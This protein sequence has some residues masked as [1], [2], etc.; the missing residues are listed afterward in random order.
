MY[1]PKCR[2]PCPADFAFCPHCGSA[3]ESTCLRCGG[4][5]PAGAAF[6]PRC[7]APLVG[8][9]ADPSRSFSGGSP[10]SAERT[11]ELGQEPHIAADQARQRALER[12]V[13]REY[14]EQLLATRD[15]PA[16]PQRRLITILFCDVVGSVAI[17]EGLDPEEV[18]EVMNGAFEALIRPVLHH[19]GTLARLMGDAI[20]A[21]FGAPVAHEDDPERAVRASLEMVENAHLYAARL[22]QERGLERFSV[23]AGI[24]TGLVA[25]GEV[26][27]DLRVEYTAMGD[28]VNLAARLEAAAPPGGV[29][30]THDTY[31]HVRGRFDVV[32][33][34]P[35]TVKG[36][37]GPVQ[38]YLVERAK[39][40]AFPIGSRGVEGIAT[41][42]VGRDAELAA[43]QQ[44][45]LDA[46]DGHQARVVTV[47]G[48]AGIGKSRLL[49]E[50]ASWVEL[51]PERV[52][53]WKARAARVS[54]SVPYGLL[55]N[56]FARRFGI[57]DSD[58]AAVALTRFR[59]GMA[60][61]L[62]AEQAD[63]AGH[64]AGFDFSSSPTVR[65]LLGS[66]SFGQIASAS[67]RRALSIL[68]RL[69]QLT[70]VP[71]WPGDETAHGVAYGPSAS[72]HEEPALLL[73]EDLHWADDASL[74]LIAGLVAEAPRARLLV[75]AAARPQ[76]LERRPNWGE[77]LD[78][79]VRLELRPLSRRSGRALV[80]E[81]L[82]RAAEVPED[83]CEML[84]DGSEGNP[85]FLEELVKMLIEDG[86]IE[87]DVERWHIDG[88]RL[89]QV[90]LPPT[91]T[92]VLQARLDALPPDERL[93]LQRASVIGRQFWDSLVVELVPEGM[94]VGAL[95]AALRSR[96]LVFRRERPAFDA[97][98]EYTFKHSFLREVTY[99]T[100]L[101]HVRRNCHG[102]VARWLE[103]HAGE[104]LGEYLALIAEHWRL[105]GEGTVAAG[106]YMRAGERAAALG[107]MT[108]ARGFF[109][110][111]LELLPPDDLALRWRALAGQ[112]EVLG[113]L[114]DSDARQAADQALLVLAQQMGDD[115]RLAE[116]H[117]RRGHYLGVLSR[118]PE[119][120]EALDAALA[121][122][123][124][125]G[126]RHLR[127]KTLP[128][129]VFTLT[130]MGRM[131]EAGAITGEAL[132]CAEMPGEPEI[133]ARAL[134]NVSIYYAAA[135]DLSRAAQLIARQA[136]TMQQVGNPV[137]QAISL[138]NLGYYYLLLGLYPK[139]RAALEHALA[140]SRAIGARREQ[141]YNQLNL[142]LACWR[143]GDG[144]TARCLL[145]DVIPELEALGDTFGRASGQN[146]LA[147]VLEHSGDAM[148]AAQVFAQAQGAMDQ[149][150]AR[151]CAADALAG[152]TRCRM[153]EGDLAAVRKSAEAL[154][155]CLTEGIGGMELP[156]LAYETCA[157]AFE[158]L[159]EAER[160]SA[161]AGDGYAFLM[162]Q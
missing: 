74:D 144:D 79:Y 46:A 153:L 31:R 2:R 23:R 33:Q 127:A 110:S 22:A 140:L 104:R 146:Y 106:W 147:L 116:A 123:V 18:L 72:G 24:N 70:Q 138:G 95:L 162:E 141:L 90:R 28:A 44:A 112:D 160:A 86:A 77:G 21:F 41:R 156:L 9:S 134:S 136:E 161:A 89:G 109:A 118:Y 61:I 43:L 53:Y 5:A 87:P 63:L 38:C 120:L 91:L 15:A 100:V 99:E 137:G 157:R 102:Q 30:I 105:A 126:N 48:E 37:P 54:Q 50:F 93:V 85:F 152:L 16:Q 35:L 82:Q 52:D 113:V 29:L 80:G 83:L 78:A 55:R 159:D 26:G 81:I 121:V 125:A 64:L 108:D 8:E 150:G 76:L 117:Y 20:L 145:E 6:C 101:L 19:H 128:L 124:R 75:L 45:Y 149:M 135:G 34:A 7:G 17:S 11:A 130:R 155:L 84:V 94:E 59:Q 47:L 97:V 57:L 98:Q 119:A 88:Q 67:L 133:L 115:N 39:P 13:P 131:P 32:P 58:S 12:M 143:T 27:I 56:L 107:E 49:D 40:R 158:M 1:C 132:A 60:G 114:G 14:M 10:S 42:M 142:G 66:P 51:R 68:W 148:G 25:V 92:A 73:L 71:Q 36:H 96:E 129:K 69:G 151:G 139:A 111:A 122:A 3:L 65:A 62:E 4:L 103:A 154:W